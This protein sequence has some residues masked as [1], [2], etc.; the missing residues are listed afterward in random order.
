MIFITLL[1]IAAAIVVLGQFGFIKNPLAFFLVITL[2]VGVAAFIFNKRLH[3]PFVKK[4]PFYFCP[5]HK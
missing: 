4:C 5:L 3:C 2:I 1:I